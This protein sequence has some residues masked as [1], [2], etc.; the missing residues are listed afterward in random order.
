VTRRCI[1]IIGMDGVLG[2]DTEI[3]V[4][5]LKVLVVFI[6]HE[7]LKGVDVLS[8]I[9]LSIYEYRDPTSNV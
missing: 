8:L 7:L 5:R 4:A 2:L 1:R 9:D 3:F 6:S